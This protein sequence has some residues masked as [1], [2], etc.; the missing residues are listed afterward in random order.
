[1]IKRRKFIKLTS[2]G[3][4]AFSIDGLTQYGGRHPESSSKPVGGS[5]IDSHMHITHGKI[6]KALQVMADNSI[7]YGVIIASLSGTG[8]DLYIGVKAFMKLLKQ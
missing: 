2:M 6:Q 5:V 1:M 7:R 4:A 3:A 8:S